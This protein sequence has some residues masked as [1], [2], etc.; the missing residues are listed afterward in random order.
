MGK[1]ERSRK[2]SLVV[3]SL[4]CGVHMGRPVRESATLTLAVKSANESVKIESTA[5]SQAAVSG[6][7]MGDSDIGGERQSC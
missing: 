7:D 6:S 3:T 5:P 1:A 4:S 2:A